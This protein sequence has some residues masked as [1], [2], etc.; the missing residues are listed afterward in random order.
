M[1]GM[2]RLIAR[3][4]L[5][6]LFFNTVHAY[7]IDHTHDGGETVQMF[8]AELEHGSDCG[9]LCEMHHL[10][11]FVAIPVT[12]IFRLPLS[13]VVMPEIRTP[14]YHPLYQPAP[15]SPPPIA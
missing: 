6:T 3:L 5:L 8:V 2:K 14:N 12:P 1:E 7:F 9:D 15:L 11:H 4:L 10:F 13:V